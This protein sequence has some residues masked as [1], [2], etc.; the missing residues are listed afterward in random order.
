MTRL[1]VK[2]EIVLRSSVFRS[3]RVGVCLLTKTAHHWTYK[4]ERSCLTL[5]LTERAFAR[6]VTT[7]GLTFTNQSVLSSIDE[8]GGLMT[9]VDEMNQNMTE[10]QLKLKLLHDKLAHCDVQHCR[11]IR[12][13]PQLELITNSQQR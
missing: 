10:A 11:E 12:V 4:K 8:N 9:V 1:A 2:D 3:I 5:M 13:Q 7:F 6:T